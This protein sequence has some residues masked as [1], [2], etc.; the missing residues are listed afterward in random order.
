M[1]PAVLEQVSDDETENDFDKPKHHDSVEPSTLDIDDRE[2][3]I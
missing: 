3:W 1:K 2:D